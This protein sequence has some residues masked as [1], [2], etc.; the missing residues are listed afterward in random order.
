MMHPLWAPDIT[1][2][3]P[4]RAVCRIVCRVPSAQ[5]HRAAYCV[6]AF[7]CVCVKVLKCTHGSLWEA[8]VAK[9]KTLCQLELGILMT[10]VIQSCCTGF[11]LSCILHMRFIFFSGRGGCQIDSLA[12]D[13]VRLFVSRHIYQSQKAEV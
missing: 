10:K 9:R 8:P 5:V 12:R 6:S 7:V 1:L 11:V 4:C 2:L 3:L 13:V